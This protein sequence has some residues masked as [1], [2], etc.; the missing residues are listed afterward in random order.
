MKRM[1]GC[2]ARR[3]AQSI[4]WSRAN[5]TSGC[6]G[7]DP[8]KTSVVLTASATGPGL[9]RIAVPPQ[10]CLFPPPQ[11][12][13]GRLSHLLT[14]PFRSY[15]PPRPERRFPFASSKLRQVL[16]SELAGTGIA[17]GA[18]ASGRL[19]GHLRWPVTGTPP[20]SSPRQH[21]PKTAA[22]LAWIRG[23]LPNHSTRRPDPPCQAGLPA[24]RRTSEL[25]PAWAGPSLPCY[26][27]PWPSNT[28][29]PCL[30]TPFTSW[31]ASG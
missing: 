4:R 16:D 1:L 22:A 21:R 2:T 17:A 6:A 26:G 10:Q 7:A 19:G 20:P 5:A 23:G 25:P 11:L 3:V 18:H 9:G 12:V 31:G 27:P 24:P 15:G 13:A 8:Q 29:R 28:G 30:P 14:G